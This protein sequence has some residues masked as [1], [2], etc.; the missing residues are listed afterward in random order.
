MGIPASEQGFQEQNVGE[1]LPEETW[2]DPQALGR[3][4]CEGLEG[5][6][7]LDALGCLFQPE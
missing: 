4:W 1:C 7:G 6:V 2:S 3:I 5:R